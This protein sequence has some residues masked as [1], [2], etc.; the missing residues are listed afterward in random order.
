MTSDD[1]PGGKPLGPAPRAVPFSPA[2]RVD[3]PA[4][5]LSRTCASR[6]KVKLRISATKGTRVRSITLHVGGRKVKTV[7]GAHK[8]VSL[9]FRGRKR[10]QVRVLVNIDA[11]RSGRR[12]TLRSRHTYRL[13]STKKQ[14]GRRRRG[15]PSG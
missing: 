13:C 6:R 12:V 11:V 9:S 1:G 15:R 4:V 8:Y 7:R 5:A 3:F 2:V 14:P 10:G